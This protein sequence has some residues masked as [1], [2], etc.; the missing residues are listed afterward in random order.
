MTGYSS[1][2]GAAAS[3]LAGSMSALPAQESQG[4]NVAAKV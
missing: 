4:E 2:V 1:H 3:I